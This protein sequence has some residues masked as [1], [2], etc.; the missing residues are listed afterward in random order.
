[1]ERENRIGLL[2]QFRLNLLPLA[3]A[4]IIAATA[5]PIELRAPVGWSGNVSYAD[6]AGNLLLYAPL[7]VALWRWRP[8]AVFLCALLLSGI[9]ETAQMWHVERFASAIDVSA[10]SLGA[11][12]GA[13]LWRRLAPRTPMRVDNPLVTPASHM[14][15]VAAVC[16]LAAN[17]AVPIRSAS[18]GAWNA[19]FPLLIGSEA[20]GE[21]RWQG[22]VHRLAVIPRILSTE[23]ASGLLRQ[24]PA[25]LP[26]AVVYVREPL[27]VDGQ[28]A[29][30]LPAEFARNLRHRVSASNQITVV[31]EITPSRASSD[32]SGS[33][34]S[35]AKDFIHRNFDLSQEGRRLTFRLQTEV[36]GEHAN[37]VMP[38]TEQILAANRTYLVVASYD[39]GVARIAIDGR[40]QARWSFVAET[41]VVPAL[42]D[43]ALLPAW[44]LFGGCLA[45]L[46]L[47]VVPWAGRISRAFT[48]MA[49]G[50]GGMTFAGFLPANGCIG[51]RPD[52][53]WCALIGAAMIVISVREQAKST[54]ES[55]TAIQ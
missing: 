4:A 21:R 22:T 16:V 5:I 36:S 50:L 14:I 17:W 20:P 7:G 1:M 31:A 23:E 8:S 12:S 46:A 45:I 37:W 27:R 51:S 3:L 9:I 55:D 40:L 26:D 54:S 44:T 47:G 2:R 32:F 10:N 33:I 42:C 13:L 18:L 11:W 24:H 30:P 43:S 19:E 6:I 15:A 35:F 39:R 25:K 52:I 49:A 38:R 29:L 34:I 48:C 53:P 41:C 28:A